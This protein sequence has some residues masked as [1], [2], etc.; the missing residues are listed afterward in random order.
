MNHIPT[1]EFDVL[2]ECHS[3]PPKPT[4]KALAKKVSEKIFEK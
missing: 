4:V 1:V 2:A 3:R